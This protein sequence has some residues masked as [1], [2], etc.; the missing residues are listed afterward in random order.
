MMPR[1][2]PKTVLTLVLLIACCSR[3]LSAAEEAP[4][5]LQ[6][7]D[8]VVFLGGTNMLRLQQSGHFE[9][10]LT[11]AFAEQ[12]PRF[13]DLSWE[14]DDVFA[15]GTVI[16]RWR[17]DGFGDRNAQLRHVGTTVAIAQFGTMESFRGQEGLADFVEAYEALLDDLGEQARLIV[18]VSPI[19]FESSINP[20]TPD[21]RQRNQDLATYVAAIGELARRRDLVFVDLFHSS[22]D[23]LTRNGMHVTP[24]AQPRLAQEIAGR[25]GCATADTES[26]EP[27][28]AA[29]REK[30]RLWY[31][32]WRPANWKLLYGDDS[33]RQFTRGGNDYI[34]FRE[35]WKRLLPL[36]E[37]AEERV[38]Q[39][40]AGQP[41]HG[42]ARPAPEKLHG[43]PSANV[44]DELRAFTVSDDLQVNLF[45]SE[46][47]G[48]TSPLAIRW[49]PTGKMYVTVTTTYPHVFP[50]DLP[51]D[52]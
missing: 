50:G 48:L 44:A 5:E 26:L 10:L 6:Q 21:L 25:L 15:L 39:V 42:A 12:K 17:P 20:H 43:D 19:R 13:R 27:L 24:E 52:K 41:D 38:W 23:N 40:A 11:H 1:W 18:L 4:F 28:R 45:A 31:D 47:H 36:I 22:L 8:V 30:H 14:A 46:E 34:P 9:T 35:E 37:K 51:N 7:D 32:Y 3:S 2:N 33:Q 16:E 29:V 49:D